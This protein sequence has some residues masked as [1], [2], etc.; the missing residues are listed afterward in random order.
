MAACSRIAAKTEFLGQGLAGASASSPSSSNARTV[1]VVSLFQKAKKAEAPA[2]KKA[3]PA[4]KKAAAPAKKA[5]QKAVSKVNS[6]SNE[7]L[8]KW[9][10]EYSIFLLIPP[11]FASSHGVF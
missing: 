11:S 4:V 7:E 5:A 10:G 6:A 3:A 1:K 8:A 9:Y 2:A